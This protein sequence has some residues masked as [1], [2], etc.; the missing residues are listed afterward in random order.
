MVTV[1]LG[2]VVLANIA[3]FWLRFDGDIPPWAAVVWRQTVLWVVLVRGLT[4]VPFRLYEGVWRYTS[5]WDLRNIGLAVVTSSA[6]SYLLIRFVLGIGNYPRSIFVIDAL[7]VMFLLGGIRLATRAYRELV[8]DRPGQGLLIYGAG[9]AGEMLVRDMRKNPAYGYEPIGFVDDDES[10]TGAR[11]HGVPVLGTRRDLPRI[12]EERRPEEILIAIPS[13]PPEVVREVVRILQPYKIP[14]KTVPRLRDIINGRVEVRHI[15][16]L[17]VEDLLARKPVNLDIRPVR[18]LVQGRRVM[19][20]GAGGSIGSELALQVARLGPA[21]LVLYERYENGLH[22]VATRLRDEGLG[23]AAHPALGDITDEGRL[24]SVMRGFR[25][26]IVF[27]AAAHKHVPLMEDN[28]CEAVKNNVMGTRLVAEA[29]ER[30][31]VHRF[32]LIS[33]DK[34]VNPVSVMGA[35]K[36]VAELFV[37]GRAPESMTSFFAVRFGN[38]LASAG[39]VVPRFLEQ[40]RAGGPVTVTHPEMRRYFMLIPEAV[41]LVLHAAA[42][43]R[44]GEVYVLRMGEQI[45]VVDLARNLIRLAGF[46][47]DEEIP[48]AFT[49]IRPGEKLYEELVAPDETVAPSEVPEIVRVQP[50]QRRDREALLGEIAELE[51]RARGEDAHAVLAQ[52]Q[53]IVP[54]FRSWRA[55]G[56]EVLAPPAPA[57]AVEVGRQVV[58]SGTRHLCPACAS[59]NVHPSR[60]RTWRER[61]KKH[62]TDARPYRCHECNW[63]GW[64]APHVLVDADGPPVPT[65]ELESVDLRALDR[66]VSGE[67]RSEPRAFSAPGGRVNLRG[68]TPGRPG[69]FGT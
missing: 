54:E 49:G 55:A 26:E 69:V 19:V 24:E 30:H 36:R 13:A 52:L 47:P 42:Q 35:T 2:L 50:R 43:G 56:V 15:R 61:V 11:I 21:Q 53:V 59:T 25:P 16:T 65:L 1:E 62:W 10:K 41:E 29:A 48:I 67:G 14:I 51:R 6:A 28:V 66:A 18:H 5:V 27:H 20:T 58:R 23:G 33:T 4:F 68:G 44:P 40:V 9:D 63:R 64:I 32:I 39:S 22:A 57:G 7:L 46:V 34:A 38:V 8:R 17:M 45:R 60:T 12:L 31:G 37:Q 3:A